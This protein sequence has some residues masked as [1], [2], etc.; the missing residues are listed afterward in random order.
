MKTKPLEPRR[1]NETDSPVRRV[2]G[3]DL[4][5]DTEGREVMDPKPIAP[6]IGYKKAPSISDT[7]RNM[8]RSE[9]LKQEAEAQGYETFEEADDF[10]VGDDYDPKSPYEEVFEPIPRDDPDDRLK[11]LGEHIGNTIF[12]KLGGD[13]IGAAPEEG[14]SKAAPADATG[15]PVP[16]AGRREPPPDP[17]RKTVPSSSSVSNRKT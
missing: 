15:K 14:P 10:D 5:Y 7:I 3:A 1:G 9:R 16:E 8:I 17:S 6:P 13:V 11:S 4:K 12:N 2:K